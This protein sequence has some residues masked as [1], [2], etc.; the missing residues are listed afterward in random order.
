MRA[1]HLGLCRFVAVLFLVAMGV[2]GAAQS[3]PLL[4]HIGGMA[5]GQHD[6]VLGSDGDQVIVLRQPVNTA[7]PWAGAQTHLATIMGSP[8]LV[9]RPVQSDLVPDQATA[10]EGLGKLLHVDIDPSSGMAVLSTF[11]ENRHSIWFSAR[12]PDNTW[13]D[14]W[15]APA[16]EPLHG[17]AAFAMFDLAE[18]REGDVVFAFKPDQKDECSGAG[19]KG[20]WKGGYDIARL[21]RRGGYNAVW[22]LD[23]INTTAHEWAMAPHPMGGGW[24]SAE[25]LNGLG[26]ADPW[27]CSAIPLDHLPVEMSGLFMNGHTLTV[28]CGSAPLEG[29]EWTV[30]DAKTGSAVLQSSSDAS[31]QVALDRLRSEGHYQWVAKPVSSCLQATAT[32][33]N[34]SGEVVQRFVLLGG[35]WRINMLTA[36]DVGSWQVR[37]TDRSRLPRLA[38]IHNNNLEVEWVVFHAIGSPG[39]RAGDSQRLK[40]WA[41]EWKQSTKGQVLVMG[42]ASVDGDPEDNRKLA[43]ERARQV[44]AQ[45]EFAGLSPDQIRVEGW[46]S[47]RPLLRCPEGVSCPRGDQE[48]SRRTELY[49]LPE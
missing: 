34:A 7:S 14:P 40:S 27:W 19:W 15:R 48:R 30:Q 44:A 9:E 6:I 31:G 18:G 25:R 4:E 17:E 5:S 36:L 42:H 49:L 3:E 13:S 12:K 11:K 32:W 22:F 29:V 23:P 35:T 28:Y 38:P 20:Q 24:L 33:T 2:S 10:W 21:P 45:L 1:I 37:P 47:E 43:N 8:W 26:G 46:G 39:I 16:L 41:N